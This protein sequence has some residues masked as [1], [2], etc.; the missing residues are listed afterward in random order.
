[1]HYALVTETWP[2]EV[3][4]VALTVRSLQR[5]L[6]RR[7]RRVSVVRP[8][9]HP[10]QVAAAAELLVRGAPVPRYPGLRL[11][12]VPAGRLQRAWAADRPDAI[13]IATEGPLGWS[14][15]RAARRLRIPVASAVHTRFD[16]YM[17]DY[18]VPLLEPL[19]LRWMRHFH[20]RADVTLAP[21]RE[22]EGFLRDAGFERPRRLARAVDTARF[23][24]ALRDRGLRNTWGAGTDEVVAIHV[25][26]IAA[27][28]NLGLAVRA[29]RELQAHRP[30]ARMVWVGDGPMRAALA[31]DN[32]DFIF[33][34]I[35]R[36]AQ[37]AR[38]F[39]S[40]DLF[41]FPSLSETFGNVTLEAMASGIATVA[42]D[43]G[44]ARE[45]LRAGI[46]GAR[47]AGEDD[48]IQAVVDIGCDDDL[49]AAMGRRAR[50]AVAGLHPDKV[51]ADFDRLLHDIATWE[52]VHGTVATA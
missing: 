11:G 3:N 48:F 5:G 24:P 36:G 41:V 37:L 38:H 46:H 9:Q 27:E 26:R 35:Q 39:A 51:A 43:Y 28:K 21:T 10:E 32:P 2:P 30:R 23:D 15:L 20:N 4:G 42:F 22:L 17:R 8:A 44:A 40:A 25:G 29:F 14:A 1:M 6:E 50:S 13:Y 12:L 34:G 33:C 49:R 18:G 45:H 47:V 52:H 7:G 31:R 16:L 19:A